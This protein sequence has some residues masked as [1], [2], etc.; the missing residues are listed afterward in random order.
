MR[1]F[2]LPI[3]L[4]LL[5]VFE[6]TFVELFSGKF[7]ASGWIVTPRFLIAAIIFVAIYVGEKQGVF[8]GLVFGLLFD[9]VYTEV[10]GIY[11]FLFPVIAFLVAK[12][13]TFLHNHVV[14][15]SMMTIIGIAVLEV[16]VYQ[17]NFLIRFTTID[18]TLF[19]INRLFP[20]II[21]NIAFLIIFAFPL[22]KQFEKYAIEL[23]NK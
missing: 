14:I 17:I 12:L 19:L 3:I 7:I 2:L 22:K 4:T 18:F 5:F 10:L 6:S 1:K 16:V 23:R 11:L 15:S 13:M 20:T 9:I 21:L 8:Y